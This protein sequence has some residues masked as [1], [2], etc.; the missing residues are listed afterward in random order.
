M[1]IPQHVQEAKDL[2]EKDY[3][4]GK[5]KKAGLV[6]LKFALSIENDGELLQFLRS[7]PQKNMLHVVTSDLDMGVVLT[8][9]INAYLKSQEQK[10]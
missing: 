4:L 7:F 5:L 1:E 8:N 6:I 10:K 2:L 9:R 3:H